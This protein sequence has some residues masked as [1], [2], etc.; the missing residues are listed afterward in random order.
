MLLCGAVEGI[1]GRNLQL[2]VLVIGH[3]TL[4]YEGKMEIPP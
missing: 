1:L 2:F 3:K 4:E